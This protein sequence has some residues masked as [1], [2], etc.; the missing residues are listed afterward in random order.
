MKYKAPTQI[1]LFTAVAKQ[2][3]RRRILAIMKVRNL[4]QKQAATL[5]EQQES[6]ICLIVNDRL[7]GFSLERLLYILASLGDEVGVRYA[8]KSNRKRQRR[9]KVYAGA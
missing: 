4:N 2:Q 1:V 6:Q 8:P 7:R 5:A 3:V 9:M